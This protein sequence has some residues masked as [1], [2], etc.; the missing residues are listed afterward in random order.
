MTLHSI[1]TFYTTHMHQAKNIDVLGK[2]CFSV[3]VKCYLFRMVC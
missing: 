2:F 3:S 1:M